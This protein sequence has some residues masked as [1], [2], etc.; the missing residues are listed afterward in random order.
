MTVQAGI[1]CSCLSAER[2]QRNR[3]GSF[4]NAA[5]KQKAG[6]NQVPAFFRLP[7][8]PATPGRP[9]LSWILGLFSSPGAGWNRSGHICIGA[10]KDNFVATIGKA[11]AVQF[12]Y[13]HAF[14]PVSSLFWTSGTR[15]S[16]TLL[17]ARAF[18]APHQVTVANGNDIKRSMIWPL[19]LEHIF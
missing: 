8:W 5:P 16:N 3:R 2:S 18:S 1:G 11:A 6:T 17:S 19:L 4:N 15:R 10:A 7:S 13:F 12:L 14:Q 9:S